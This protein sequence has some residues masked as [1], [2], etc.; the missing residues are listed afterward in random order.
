MGQKEEPEAED[1]QAL[2]EGADPR[3]AGQGQPEH[4]IHAGG[5]EEGHQLGSL[6]LHLEDTGQGKHSA[7]GAQK[8]T[9]VFQASTLDPD[10]YHPRARPTSQVGRTDTQKASLACPNQPAEYE[11]SHHHPEA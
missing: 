8:H 7:L 11:H 3:W 9:E 1:G 5:L 6:T 10:I 4:K 2:D